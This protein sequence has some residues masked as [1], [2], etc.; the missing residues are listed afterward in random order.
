[1]DCIYMHHFARYYSHHHYMDM[2]VQ[3][4]ENTSSQSPPVVSLTCMDPTQRWYVRVP[5]MPYND[6]IPTGFAGT[7]YFWYIFCVYH[8]LCF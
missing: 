1:M 2:H 5:A 8:Y 4:S 7:M 6:L 3:H